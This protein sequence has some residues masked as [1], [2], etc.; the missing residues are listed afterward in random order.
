M[1]DN[2]TP[3]G[4][5]RMVNEGLTNSPLTPAKTATAVGVRGKNLAHV[6]I[7]AERL[8]RFVKV[9]RQMTSFF[10]VAAL[11]WSQQDRGVSWKSR[12]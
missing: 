8:R 3:V 12:R 4:W 7:G 9:Q 2:Q 11:L 1:D 5:T 10:H 6:A